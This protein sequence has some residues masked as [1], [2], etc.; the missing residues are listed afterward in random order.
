MRYFR[1][2]FLLFVVVAGGKVPSF[3]C[4]FSCCGGGFIER[5]QQK[6]IQRRRVNLV[7]SWYPSGESAVAGSPDFSVFKEGSTMRD[8]LHMLGEDFRA[9]RRK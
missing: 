7:F 2:C 3:H 6:D 8:V 9:V 4:S 1:F 5:L